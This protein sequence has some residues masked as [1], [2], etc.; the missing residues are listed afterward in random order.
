M[1]LKANIPKRHLDP[2]IKGEFHESAIIDRISAFLHKIHQAITWTD[3]GG[4]RTIIF[5]MHAFIY[6]LQVCGSCE[7]L[8]QGLLKFSTFLFVNHNQKVKVK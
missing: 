8:Y 4:V 1:L 7:L 2:R 6:S 5:V 3:Y